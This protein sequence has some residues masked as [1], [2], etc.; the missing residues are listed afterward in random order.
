MV[1]LQRS[2]PA[3]E[4]RHPV[5]LRKGPIDQVASDAS[6]RAEDYQL[7]LQLLST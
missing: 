3:R 1:Q 7:H 2:G 6:R 5:V 4:G